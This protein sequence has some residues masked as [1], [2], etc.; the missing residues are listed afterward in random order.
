[1]L[2]A[3]FP[4]VIVPALGAKVPA[5]TVSAPLT[6][7]LAVGWVEGVALVVTEEKLNDDPPPKL[8][9]QPVPER[10]MVPPVGAKVLLAAMVKAPR[11]V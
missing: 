7:K 5:L 9:V 8:I 3:T 4:M 10:V 1:M 2:D 11:I 6:V